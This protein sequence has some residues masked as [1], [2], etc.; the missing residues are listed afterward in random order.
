MARKLSNWLESYLKYT[1]NSE[2]PDLYRLWV[3]ISVIASVLQRKVYLQWEKKTFPNMYIVLV[4]PSGKCRKGTAMYP[5]QALLRGI[6]V[7]MSAD[8]ITREALIQDIKGAEETD[9]NVKDN[10]INIHSSLTIFSKELTVFLGYN[11]APLMSALTDWYDCDDR[12]IYRTKHMGTDEIINVWVNLIGATTPELI[13][14]ALPQDAIGGGLSS[15]IIFV[16]EEDKGKIVPAPFLTPFDKRLKKSLVEDLGK[17]QM[18]SGEFKITEEFMNYWIDWYTS[19]TKNP[20]IMDSKFSGYL[21]RRPHHVLKLSMI[22]SA[23]ED[24]SLLVD[25]KH[26]KEAIAILEQ[27][28]IKMPYTFSG[29]G[30]SDLSEVTDRII[31]TLAI[32][33]KISQSELLRIYYLDADKQTLSRIVD[34]LVSMDVVKIHYLGNESML[35]YISKE[36][37]EKMER[38]KEGRR[39]VRKTDNQTTLKLKDKK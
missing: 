29:M 6:G 24:D 22:L 7:N 35:E 19:Q 34:T 38:K 23:A 26:M 2:P 4:G 37:R 21:Q 10:I 31:R 36:K 8:S 12:W 1:L 5:G 33:G 14:T 11:N 15:R 39:I 17:L 20:P 13:Q 3:G 16:Y 30:Q 9:I 28:E 18:M 27:T 32:R 25:T